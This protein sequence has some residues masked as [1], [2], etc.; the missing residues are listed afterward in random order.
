M[1]PLTPNSV[2]RTE[3]VLQSIYLMCDG[4]LSTRMI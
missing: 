4:S 2:K 3:R 1:T